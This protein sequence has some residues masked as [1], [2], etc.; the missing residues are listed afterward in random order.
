MLPPKML[1][2]ACAIQRFFVHVLSRAL[3][4]STEAL[5]V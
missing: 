2:I 5:T 1:S 3:T 4:F